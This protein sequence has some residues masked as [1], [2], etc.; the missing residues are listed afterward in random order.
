MK[1]S[2]KKIIFAAFF[3]AYLTTTSADEVVLI[4]HKSNNI[5][6]LSQ[7]DLRGIYLGKLKLFPGVKHK[8]IPI[9]QNKSSPVRKTFYRAI[10]GMSTSRLNRYWSK[11]IFSGRGTPPK[12][13]DDDREMIKLIA[14]ERH[15][16]GYVYK[17]SLNDSVKVINIK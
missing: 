11:K 4:V 10:I 8:V 5:N 6:I 17:S 7:A 2:I 14:S 12:H 15:A 16:L 13:V 3:L 1:L 9:D